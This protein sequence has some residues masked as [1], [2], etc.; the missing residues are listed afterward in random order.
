MVRGA[1][2][3]R[4]VPKPQNVRKSLLETVGRRCDLTL[5]NSSFSSMVRRSWIR[6]PIAKIEM[7]A[8][9][10]FQNMTLPLLPIRPTAR[11]S[12][13]DRGAFHGQ[14]LLGRSSAR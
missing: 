11:L 1:S 12:H 10:L 8:K 2:V 5:A 14:D 7:A 9:R 4:P 6:R 3:S 13:L